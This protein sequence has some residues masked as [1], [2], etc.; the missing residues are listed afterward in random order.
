MHIRYF[1]A[2]LGAAALVA[3]PTAGAHVTLHPNA[4]PRGAFARVVVRVPNEE[5]KAST[6]KVDVKFPPGFLFAS[7]LPV[8]GWK[9]K[10][11]YAKLATPVT[12]FGSKITEQVDRVVFTSTGGSLKPGQF[13]EFPLSLGF[14]NKNAGY[15]AFKALQTYSNGKVVRWI[16]APDAD[17]PAP[18]VSVQGKT[19]P[20]SDFAETPAP[21]SVGGDRPAV[22]TAATESADSD[23]ASETLGIV[24]LI[25]GALGVLVGSVALAATRRRRV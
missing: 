6:T 12:A 10:I 16:G 9:A 7:T 2:A 15:L 23:T 24:A 22:A 1:S 8:Q 3:A 13:Q 4:V 21:N 11:A 17:T 5:A 14:P 20:I 18:R 19:A 25:A